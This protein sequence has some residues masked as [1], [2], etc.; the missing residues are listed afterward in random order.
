MRDWCVYFTIGCN[1]PLLQS[2]DVN[3]QTNLRD[4]HHC[5]AHDYKPNGD[6]DESV[7]EK[8]TNEL[9]EDLSQTAAGGTTLQSIYTTQ[10]PQLHPP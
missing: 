3:S 8:M 4:I 2:K 10:A 1:L 7:Y 5:I 6:D 9:I